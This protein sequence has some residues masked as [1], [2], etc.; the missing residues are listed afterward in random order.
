MNERPTGP[1]PLSQ[2]RSSYRSCGPRRSLRLGIGDARV[3]REDWVGVG[4]SASRC[5]G[6]G[7]G[8]A[9]G[10]REMAINDANR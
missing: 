4:D 9:A 6:P 10:G 8:E 7:R 2:V 5:T 1:A 3:H